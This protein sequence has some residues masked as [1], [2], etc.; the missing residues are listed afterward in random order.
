MLIIFDFDGVLF[1]AKWLNLFRAHEAIIK[2][3]GKNP[4]DFFK[5]MEE[6][7][8]WWSPDWHINNQK[9]GIKDWDKNAEIFYRVYNRGLGLFP[10]THEIV[11]K[12]S[13]RYNLAILTNRHKN[14][15]GKYLKSIKKYFLFI[16]GCED[17]KKLK[18]DS[19]GINLILWKTGATRKYTLMIGDAVDDIKASKAAGINSGIVKWGLDGKRNPES[20]KELLSLNPDYAFEKYEDL[21]GI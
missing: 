10:W 2:A 11:R 1:K 20:W 7:R 8:K 12:L 3:A 6:F 19:E 9:I 13:K 15:A 17:V 4:K 21:L 5:N 14:D 16:A 18:P